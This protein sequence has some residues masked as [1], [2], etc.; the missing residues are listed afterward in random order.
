MIYSVSNYIHNVI[1][2]RL[3]GCKTVIDMG[4]L[5]KMKRRGFIVTNANI[6]Y[7]LDATKL[8]FKDN[9]FDAAISIA[10]LEH[11]GEIKE[12]DKFLSESIRVAKKKIIH[13]F[14]V[15]EEVEIFLA[16]IGHKHPATMT[17]IDLLERYLSSF[18]IIDRITVREHLL[19]L[20]MIYPQLN[21]K[22]LYDYAFKCGD[23]D[24]GILVEMNK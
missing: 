24:Y 23:K 21:V 10:V 12:Q 8:P 18:K 2:S 5:G 3:Q 15:N 4:G 16:N 13:W 11:V 14:P 9:S 20:V 7:G 22:E 6:K 19:N 1:S 17:S